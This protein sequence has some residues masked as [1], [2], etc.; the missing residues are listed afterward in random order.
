[1]VRENFTKPSVDDIVEVAY[2]MMNEI[3]P[4]LYPK[5]Y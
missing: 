4:E 3:N 1:M 5:F 2:A